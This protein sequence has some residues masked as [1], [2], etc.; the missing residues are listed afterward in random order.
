MAAYHLASSGKR[1]LLVDKAVFPRDKPCGGGLTGRAVRL[2][3]FP[4][5][6]VVEQEVD[7]AEV[8]LRYRSRFERRASAPLVL[9]TQ[10]RRLDYY[11]L[12]RAARAGAEVRDG[13]RV[14]VAAE[15]RLV[16]DGREIETRT[17]VVADGANGVTARALGLGGDVVHGVALEGNIPY[18]SAPRDRFRGRMVLELAV[19]P[20]GYG[21]I[22][23]KGEHVNVGVGGWQHEG[24]RLRRHLERL[25]REHG[26]DPATV[27]DIR[28]H[29]LPM[30][31]SQHAIASERAVLV[32]D[33]AGL[34]DP[35]SGDGM[36]E[37]L[38]S[39]RLAASA[40]VDVLEGRAAGLGAYELAVAD[41]IGLLGRAG[42][43]AKLALDRFPRGTFAV[44][45]LPVTWR[46]V[47]KLLL[48]ELGHPGA[49]RGAERGAIRLIAG[50][51]RLADCV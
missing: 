5:D 45:R 16:V 6:A 23:P 32:G 26:L 48:G 29:R 22:F 37:A 1:V 9:M 3:P 31:R 25:C 27:E 47:E 44:A 2:L 4:V 13:V 34:I 24:P 7:I 50:I 11:L 19:V 35:F 8:R 18:A 36:Y 20:G 51:A 49:A 10:R 21:W 41:S 14:E 46:V 30:R 42:W 40:A 33:A 15:T 43:Q 12:E 28:G 39:A 38:L 17:L